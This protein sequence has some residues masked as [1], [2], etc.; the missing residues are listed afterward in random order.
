MTLY[1]QLDKEAPSP[2]VPAFL[3]R[4]AEP[5]T[6][7]SNVVKAITKAKRI[8]VVCG[9]YNAIYSAT[10]LDGKYKEIYMDKILFVFQRLHLRLR[11]TIVFQ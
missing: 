3:S 1:V 8:A 11:P 4:S 6:Y 7:I 2:Q 10:F 9:E 5:A